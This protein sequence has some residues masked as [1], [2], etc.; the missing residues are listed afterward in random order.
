MVYYTYRDRVEGVSAMSRKSGAGKYISLDARVLNRIEYMRAGA[1]HSWNARSAQGG[2]SIQIEV[3]SRTEIRM[4]HVNKEG[5]VLT[6]GT[7]VKLTSESCDRGRNRIWFHCPDCLRVV[8]LLYLKGDQFKCWQCQGVT[9]Y[10]SWTRQQSNLE[11]QPDGRLV[12][13]SRRR[14][15]EP[16]ADNQESQEIS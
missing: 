2:D 7:L 6:T 3:L 11:Q 1:G 16:A 14:T 10:N 15:L 9:N 5:S 4:T 12:R 8:A 13:R